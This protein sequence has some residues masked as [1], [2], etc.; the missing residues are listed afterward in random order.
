MFTT[1]RLF[2]I[3]LTQ[4]DAEDVFALGRD[5]DVARYMRFE[6]LKDL[7]E[8]QKLVDSYTQGKNRGFAVRLRSDQSFLGVFALKEEQEPQKYSLSLF[9][10]QESWG[11]GYAAELIGWAKHRGI[12][13]I[14]G[15]TLTGYV[16][17]ENIPSQKALEK[18]GFRLKDT[19]TFDDLP[20]GLCIYE[21]KAPLKP[22]GVKVN[23]QRE[24]DQLLLGLSKEERIP[25]LFLHSCCAPCSS[26]VLEYLSDYFEITV[27]YYNPNIYPEE[28][29]RTRVEEQRQFIQRLTPAH[30]VHL[31]EGEYDT[32]SFYEI[33]KG[34]EQEPEGGERCFACYRLRLEEAAKYAKEKGFDYFTTTLT[35]SPYKNAQKLNEIGR[36]LSAQYGVSY[37][38]SD[39]K[40]K[41]G[42]RRSIELSEEYGL[43]R[44]DY[45]GCVYSK[46]E[47]DRIKQEKE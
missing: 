33:A 8:A 24:L 44:Q 18:N 38:Y 16:V 14:P 47:R 5:E 34:H 46:M 4:E 1:S 6:P 35:I 32:D 22:Y 9:L 29:Y 30:P 7:E 26:Y 45:C 39:F 3:P 43:Y 36:E 17:G 42:Y 40:K 28:E 10:K 15:D 12:Q 37:L 31:L 23:Y 21:W 25:T 41:N 13:L 19:R 2:L 11:H 27:F 20:Q